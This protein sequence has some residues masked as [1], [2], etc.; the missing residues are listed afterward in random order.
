MR[1]SFLLIDYLHR[2]SGETFRPE[3]PPELPIAGI[4]I[5]FFVDVF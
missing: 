1:I 5:L 3:A 4:D 2:Q